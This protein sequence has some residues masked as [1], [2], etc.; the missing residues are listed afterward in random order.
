[1]ARTQVLALLREAVA[2]GAKPAG[3]LQHGNAHHLLWVEATAGIR[4]GPGI[5]HVVLR[6]VHARQLL[7]GHPVVI[8]SIGDP[9]RCLAPSTIWRKKDV[10][11]MCLKVIK[12]ENV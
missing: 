7:P 9:P 8:W 3:S 1:M 6:V 2:I 10:D 5:H 11:L 12:L 4:L